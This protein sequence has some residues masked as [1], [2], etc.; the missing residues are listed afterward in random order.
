MK[1]NKRILNISFWVALLTILFI[2]GN[3]PAEGANRTEYGFP[4]RFFTQYH[5]VPKENKW[6]I[7][8][9]SIELISY[10]LNVAFI[11]A[12]LLGVVHIYNRFKGR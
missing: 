11:Y 7:Q 4:M 8:G 10:F 2:P 9:I 3:S 12:L 6:F 5:H 1:I